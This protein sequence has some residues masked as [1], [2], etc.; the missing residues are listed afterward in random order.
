MRT[1]WVKAERKMPWCSQSQSLHSSSKGRSGARWGR[2]FHSRSVRIPNTAPATSFT[3]SRSS[4]S[5]SAPGWETRMGRASSLVAKNTATKVPG[6]IS[7]P[8]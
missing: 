2:R 3:P 5:G 1:V 7:R 4:K 8:A 6:V